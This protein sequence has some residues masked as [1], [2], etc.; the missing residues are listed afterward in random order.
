MME[1]IECLY[2]ACLSSSAQFHRV[3]LISY[4]KHEKNN[5]K[6]QC[7]NKN[8]NSEIYICNRDNNYDKAL[9]FILGSLFHDAVTSHSKQRPIVER[10]LNDKLECVK[11]DMVAA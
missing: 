3:R 7:N 11:K 2:N 8:D 10:Q 5:S 6:N 1:N 4:D 9:V